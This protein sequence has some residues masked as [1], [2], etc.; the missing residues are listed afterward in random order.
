MINFSR[1][2]Q[3]NAFCVATDGRSFHWTH[4][5]WYFPLEKFFL[6]SALLP[7]IG[8]ALKF[9]HQHP[10]KP[11]ARHRIGNGKSSQVVL[12]LKN[13]FRS[14]RLCVRGE[15]DYS[16]VFT[17]PT[18]QHSS[19]PSPE[20]TY[21][22]SE[23]RSG[24]SV[25]N[26]VESSLQSMQSRSVMSELLKRKRSGCLKNLMTYT[27]EQD[28]RECGRYSVFSI[29]IWLVVPKFQ[30]QVSVVN[31]CAHDVA[32]FDSRQKQ[33]KYEAFVSCH[34]IG[35]LADNCCHSF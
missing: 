24:N 14:H 6:G 10:E 25:E 12:V 16:H 30:Y 32:Q 8:I 1:I 33:S 11:F 26:T 23:Q 29:L 34:R 28:G 17:R 9:I 2:W 3:G 7:K 19:P 18:G 15:S 20:E 5:I 27:K 21:P 4:D 31:C 35:I 13:L 22:N